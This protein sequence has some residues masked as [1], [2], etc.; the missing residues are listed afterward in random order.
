[1]VTIDYILAPGIE[2]A[3]FDKLV[4]EMNI[5]TAKSI[6]KT[7]A[8]YYDVPIEKVF[9]NGRDRPIATVRMVSSWFIRR[10]VNRLTLRQISELFGLVYY[11]RNGKYDHSAI[12]H[13]INTV[14]GWLKV[15]DP[16]ADDVK[17]LIKI[18]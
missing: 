17:T 8:K 11:Q 3:Y 2:T 15:N 9:K 12:I 18:I 16:I 10:K 4:K 1:M 7:V 6:I 14:N 5:E 13:N